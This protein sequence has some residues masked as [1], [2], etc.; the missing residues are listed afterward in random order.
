MNHARKMGR[1]GV[2][3]RVTK[4]DGTVVSQ[5]S[6][7]GWWA[8]KRAELALQTALQNRKAAVVKS[9]LDR[10]IERAIK[11]ATGNP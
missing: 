9:P 8:R 3:E 4:A 5:K 2:I 7:D 6:I 10:R 1:R 11:K